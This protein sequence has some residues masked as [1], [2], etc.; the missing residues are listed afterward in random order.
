MLISLFAA[1]SDPRIDPES[2]W[3]AWGRETRTYTSPGPDGKTFQC[4]TTW[5]GDPFT[6]IPVTV[7]S[8]GAIEVDEPATAA[9]RFYRLCFE[10]K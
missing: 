4:Y 6:V 7:T 2:V 3:R 10:Q 5:Q 1:M 9:R 8:A